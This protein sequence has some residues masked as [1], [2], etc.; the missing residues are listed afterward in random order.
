MKILFKNTTKYDK[1]NCN[2][3]INFHY[4]KYA[5]KTLIKYLLLC[6]CVLY[7]IIFNMINKNWYLIITIA[8]VSVLLYFY[9]K[10]KKHNKR[11]ERKKIKQYTFYFYKNYIKIKYR[12]EY[13]RILYL[14]IKKVFETE[15]NFFLYTDDTHSLILDK[16]GF[17]IGNSKEFSKFIKTKCPFKY[18][19]QMK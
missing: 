14:N 10:L 1:E 18:S 11:K 4:D 2:N 17:T 7:I 3:F 9:E 19:D 13:D 12:R 16:D 8:V 15:N 5:K 6:V